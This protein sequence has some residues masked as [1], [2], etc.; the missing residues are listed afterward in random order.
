VAG[1]YRTFLTQQRSYEVQ[2][3]VIDMQQNVR[4]ALGEM[5]REIRMAGLG[6]LQSILPVTVNGKTYANVVNPDTPSAGALTI[7]AASGG[8]TTLK[9]VGPSQNQIT[10]PGSGAALFDTANRRYLSIAGIESFAITAIAGTTLTLNRS[11][12]STFK[13]D[14]T[15]PVLAVRAITFSLNAGI[16]RRDGN[17]G[18]GAQPL[19]DGIENV[20]FQFFDVNG[21]VT[22]NPPDIRRIQVTA[23][24]V[25]KNPDPKM[26]VG[27]GRRRRQVVSNI[28]LRNMGF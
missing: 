14:G 27:D 8:S 21:T 15:V 10:I 28:V 24:A 26:T 11:V 19:S 16:L 4:V 18:G 1:I 23:T 6:S 3:D 9:G 22:A 7:V 12:S 5:A 2:D 17:L 25:S 20:A 13:F